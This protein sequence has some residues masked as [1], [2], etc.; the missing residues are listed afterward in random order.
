[1][2]TSSRL[3]AGALVVLFASNAAFFV[4]AQM[5]SSE[6]LSVSLTILL[7]ATGLKILSE[8]DPP[9]RYYAAFAVCLYLE[10]MTRHVNSVF[11]GLLPLASL[12]GVLTHWRGNGEARA[13]FI[14]MLMVSAALGLACMLMAT[15]TTKLLCRAFGLEYRSI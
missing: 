5:V 6:A 11:A 3:M 2:C 12:L 9:G 10:L 7:I 15:W 1:A 14:R 8:E 4:P 13:R